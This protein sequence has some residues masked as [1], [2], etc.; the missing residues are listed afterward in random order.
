MQLL[1]D[2]CAE[3]IRDDDPVA[4]RGVNAAGDA[5]HVPARRR[6]RQSDQ[7]DGVPA[8]QR[9]LE[10]MFEGLE[11]MLEAGKMNVRQVDRARRELLDWAATM[12]WQEEQEN[13]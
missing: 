11:C 3:P 13:R 7:L 1:C 12:A 6:Q 5:D 2:D 9:M 4:H 10:R 8:R